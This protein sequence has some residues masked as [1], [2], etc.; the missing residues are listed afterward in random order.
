M[1]VAVLDDGSARVVEFNSIHSSGLYAIDGA[2][3]AEVVEEAVRR[4]L[5]VSA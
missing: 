3:F 4:R 2:A 1:D 5:S